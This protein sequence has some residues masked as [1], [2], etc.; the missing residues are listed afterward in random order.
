MLARAHTHSLNGQGL[1][2]ADMVAVAAAIKQVKPTFILKYV[3]RQS[4]WAPCFKCVLAALSHCPMVP[5]IVPRNETD[6]AA[7]PHSSTHTVL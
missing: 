3:P 1:V 4:N 6:H 2:D 5:V 7:R